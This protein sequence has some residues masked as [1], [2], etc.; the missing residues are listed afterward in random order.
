MNDIV[1]KNIKTPV[2]ITTSR[3][4]ITEI[5]EKDKEDY[6]K[7]Y[8]DESLNKLWGYDYTEDIHSTP[9]PEDFF[10]L[11]NTLKQTENEFAFAVRLNDKMI[12]ELVLYN[13]E[14]DKSVEIGFR[15]FSEFQKKGYATESALALMQ[16]AKRVLG[17]KTIKGRCFKQNINSQAL[18]LRL[19]FVLSHSDSEKHYFILK[20]ACD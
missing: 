14:E 18:F 9:T 3:L 8:T 2:N 17:A 4:T 10:N 6:F 20:D 16:Y 15:F 19:G 1:T 5:L 11:Q 12:G 13:P 7:L